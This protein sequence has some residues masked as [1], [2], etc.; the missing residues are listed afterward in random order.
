M[1]IHQ[2]S[3][4]NQLNGTR[5]VPLR[6]ATGGMLATLL[7]GGVTV[8]TAKKDVIIDVNGE[9][10]ALTTLSGTV[11]GALEQAGVELGAQDFVSPA[12]DS[13]LTSESVVTVRTAKQVALVVDG[14]EETLT[15]TA[16]SVEDLLGE[17]DEIS[18]ADAID[19]DPDTTIPDSG[20]QL[21]VT[22][23]KIISI[24]DGGRVV[25]TS[26]AA[27]TVG[28][29]LERRGIT[30]DE[31]DRLN[32]DANHRITT[33]TEIIIDRVETSEVTET[34]D[35][36][37]PVTYVDDP[38]ADK[39]TETVVTEGTPGAKEITRQIVT[40]NGVEAE[41]TVLR[42]V[43]L[44]AATPTTIKRGTKAAPATVSSSTSGSAAPSVAGGSVWDALAQ[45]ESNG[46]WSINTGNG[47]SGG[48]Q[49]HPQTWQAYGGGQY[50]PT[51]AGAS[52]EQQIAIAQ[53]VQAA[54]GWG[55]WPAC[56]AKLGIR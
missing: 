33:N 40:V 2:K 54:Q 11:E 9:Q 28:E 23:P 44:T 43:E 55:A 13:S 41:N 18:P 52:R 19:A 47:F 38:E 34:V 39:G 51:A 10:I 37:A 56:T 30:I 36:A 6:L 17:L 46:N 48:L 49:F 53:K 1:A 31:D 25:Y 5:S 24:N 8:A 35:I 21:K 16:V 3:R 42:E 29:V 22:K 27:D 15:T 7:I 32:L 20:L 26:I 45:C 4:I 14:R 12:P 50:A